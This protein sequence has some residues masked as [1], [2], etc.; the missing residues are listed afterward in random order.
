MLGT[1]GKALEEITHCQTKQLT[2]HCFIEVPCLAAI[3]AVP[4]VAVHSLA[5]S[6]CTDPSQL[7]A[8]LGNSHKTILGSRTT[9]AVDRHGV[10]GG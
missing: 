3:G 7:G 5:C 6:P 2:V 9:Q 8:V 10:D 4:C 1:I